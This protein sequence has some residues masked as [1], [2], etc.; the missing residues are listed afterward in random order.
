MAWFSSMSGVLPAVVLVLV[1]L[2]AVPRQRSP[3]VPASARS[4][5]WAGYGTEASVSPATAESEL[6]P[7]DSGS[8]SA[9]WGETRRVW[10]AR[11]STVV[12]Q[13]RLG[14][15]RSQ[16]SGQGSGLPREDW[17]NVTWRRNNV[18]VDD[19]R[20][21]VTEAGHLNIT[22]VAKRRTGLTDEGEYRC[23]V[24]TPMGVI[25]GPPITLRVA[26]M[27]KSLMLKPSN[28][29]VVEG[30]SVRLTCQIDSEPPATF[31][32]TLDQQSLPQDDRYA[33]FNS[34]V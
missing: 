29:S 10:A 5:R 28:V 4:R 32:W 8:W 24:S 11:G 33:T 2:T 12:L 23:L 9:S 3:L 31:T 15:A 1:V 26:T 22:K 17:I 27:T 6:T 21:I 30:E 18:S 19:R 34:G 13:C 7:G 20:H 14:G 16:G 25:T